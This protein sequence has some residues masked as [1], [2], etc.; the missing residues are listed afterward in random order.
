MEMNVYHL[1]YVDDFKLHR[2]S[3]DDLETLMNTVRI[4]TDDIKIRFDIRKCGILVMKRGR[5]KTRKT[6]A[7]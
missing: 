1:L 6:N 2:K 5:Y 3:K 7:K 4:L